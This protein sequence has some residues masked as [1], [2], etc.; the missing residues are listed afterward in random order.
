M[1]SFFDPD[2]IARTYRDPLAVAVLIVDLL[3]ILAVLVFGWAATPLVALY[4]LENLVIGLFTIL[5]M[6]ASAAGNLGNLL[7]LLFI[8]PFFT[9]HYGMFCYGHGVFIQA[10]SARGVGSG[11]PAPLELVNWA[12][13]TGQGM[14]WFVA[15]ILSINLVIYVADYL[16]KGEFR[17]ANPQI[18]MFAPY[19]RIV[20]LHVAILLGAVFALGTNEPLL[21]VLFLIFLRVVFGMI[22]SALRQRKLDRELGLPA[23]DSPAPV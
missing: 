2:L 8:I 12:I 4:W 5:R 22:L 13:N 17:N 23:T 16:L 15:A 20:T 3:P 7:T 1:R 10:L 21:G 11:N 19:G 14:V 9:V 6:A 18:E